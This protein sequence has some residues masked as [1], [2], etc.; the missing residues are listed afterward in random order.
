MGIARG[1][2]QAPP[3][4]EHQLTLNDYIYRPHFNGPDLSKDDEQR[5]VGQ[6]KRVYDCM[7]DGQWRTL[8]QIAEITSAPEASV[9]AQL[10]NLRK[11][12][13]GGHVVERQNLGGGLYEYRLNVHV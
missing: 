9:S 12:R 2:V 7:K 5:L 10:R 8:K 1:L 3:M 13:F 11:P 4:M 6:M